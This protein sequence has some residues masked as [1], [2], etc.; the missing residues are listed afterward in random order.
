M[1]ARERRAIGNLLGEENVKFIERAEEQGLKGI[2]MEAAAR[3]K[4]SEAAGVPRTES[5]R[6][7]ARLATTQRYNTGK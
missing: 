5:Q 1:K 6:R 4:L 3:A 7:G 2:A